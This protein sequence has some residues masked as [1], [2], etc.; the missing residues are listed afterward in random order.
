ML[1]AT[2]VRLDRLADAS[3]ALDRPPAA[4]GDPS[5]VR[6]LAAACAVTAAAAAA[7]AATARDF[8][9][10]SVCGSRLGEGRAA[11]LRA[12]RATRAARLLQLRAKAAQLRKCGL[13]QRR[14]ARAARA[15]ASRPA[16]RRRSLRRSA[17]HVKQRAAWGIEGGRL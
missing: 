10:G 16:H 7:A 6:L 14:G 15:V 5:P 4:G 17:V 12:A 11:A 9:A 8:G 2:A 3:V 1:L 13:V